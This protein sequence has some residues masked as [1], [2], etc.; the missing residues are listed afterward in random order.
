MST[1]TRAMAFTF[2]CALPHCEWTHPVDDANAPDVDRHLLEHAS[3]HSAMDYLE[4]IH[5]QARRI[6][7]LENQLGAMNAV[8]RGQA[9][10]DSCR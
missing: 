8:V 6:R 3:S 9:G 4:A 2:A 7:S 5:Q 10:G 1:F